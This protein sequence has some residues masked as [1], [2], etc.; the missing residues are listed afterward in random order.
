VTSQSIR[1]RIDRPTLVV[2]LS[3]IRARKRSDFHLPNQWRYLVPDILF[4]EM[5]T[6]SD[7][8]KVATHV[9]WFVRQNAEKLLVG[10]FWDD[11]ADAE[12]RPGKGSVLENVVEWENTRLLRAN[13]LPSRDEWLASAPA[14]ALSSLGDRNSAGR[15][16]W[17]W[18]A[19]RFAEWL[20]EHRREDKRSL[21]SGAGIVE[22]VRDRPTIVEWTVREWPRLD[23]AEW[24]AA[25]DVFPDLHAAARGLRL[26]MWAIHRYAAGATRDFENLWEDSQYA[27]L[28]SY[29]NA[30]LTRDEGLA[31][32]TAVVF[33]GVRLYRDLPDVYWPP[34]A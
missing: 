31:R 4:R 30:L 24:R 5:V 13:R 2:D 32:M 15:Q 12:S 33:P 28:A 34:L 26:L 20:E 8:T 16:T 3:W 11:V 27:F 17:I 25:L 18:M 23:T 22:M 10:K 9:W 7:V 29:S 19:Q 1:G 21:L 14:A 6:S